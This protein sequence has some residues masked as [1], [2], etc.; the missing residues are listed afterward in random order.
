M[1]TSEL[2]ADVGLR[3]RVLR[4]L[5]SAERLRAEWSDLWSR[6]SHATT[7]QRPEWLLAWMRS[8]EPAQPLLIEVRRSDQLVGIVP[9]LIYQDGSERV[10]A[11]MGGGISDYLDVLVDPDFADETLAI[12]WNYIKE[13]PDWTTLDLTENSSRWTQRPNYSIEATWGTLAVVSV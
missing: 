11:L 9:L 12:I 7:F 5:A 8:F 1:R 3:A 13:E 6:C 10:L 4:D 2:T